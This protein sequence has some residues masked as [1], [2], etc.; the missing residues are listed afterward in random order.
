M[1]A[2]SDGGRGLTLPLAT[3]VE[4]ERGEIWLFSGDSEN[5]PPLVVI[6]TELKASLNNESTDVVDTT[7][8]LCC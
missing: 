7:A 1:N 8:A 3:E 5:P 4:T 6:V 2:C